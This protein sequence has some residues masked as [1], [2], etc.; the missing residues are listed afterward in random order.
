MSAG[1]DYGWGTVNRDKANGIHYGVIAVRAIAQAWSDSSES[2]YG[3]ATCP[4]CEGRAVPLGPAHADLDL[5]DFGQYE[6]Q[7]CADYVCEECKL[8]IDSTDCFPE[9][10]RG[11]NCADPAY[12]ASTCFDGSCVMVTRAPYF[13]TARF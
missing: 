5:D 9:E 10:A 13:T 8:T 1:I 6:D 2:D 3:E 4:K 7:G 12:D 11:W